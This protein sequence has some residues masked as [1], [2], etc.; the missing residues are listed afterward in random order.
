MA[1]TPIWNP[2][3]CCVES[4]C[5]RL[6]GLRM[7]REH[8]KTYDLG[9]LSRLISLILYFWP[10]EFIGILELVQVKKGARN[11]IRTLKNHPLE[12]SELKKG[13]IVTH[14]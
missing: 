11:R 9:P 8:Q 1:T 5:K 3:V 10:L 12:S 4:D 6:H 14:F 13:P 2:Q 7:E